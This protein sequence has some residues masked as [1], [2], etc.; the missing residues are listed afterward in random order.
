MFK[1]VCS[2]WKKRWFLLILPLILLCGCSSLG[3]SQATPTATVIANQASLAATA[4]ANQASLA[5][6]AAAQTVF[7]TYVGK[8]EVHDAVLTINANGTGLEQWNAGPCGNSMCGGNAQ[9]TFTVNTDGS[10]KGT[11]QSVSYAQGNGNPTPAGFQ[12]DP[13]DQ[14]AGDTFQLQ[15]SGAHLL[16]ATWFGQASSHNTFNRYW[17]GSGASQAEQEKCGA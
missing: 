9:I 6:T 13:S 14:R 2:H 10:I 17:C 3:A 4:A 5:A 1:V 7:K 8:W 15:H 12:P 16:Y 11:I